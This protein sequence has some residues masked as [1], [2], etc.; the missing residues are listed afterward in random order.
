[1][2]YPGRLSI[3]AGDLK[4]GR[5]EGQREAEVGVMCH[6]PGNARQPIKAE[7]GQGSC[8]LEPPKGIQPYQ[9]LDLSPVRSVLDF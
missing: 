3:I 6:E 9:H 1:M 7:K 5:Q 2:D 4:R 8:P